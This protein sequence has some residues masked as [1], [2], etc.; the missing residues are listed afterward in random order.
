MSQ[1]QS[2]DNNSETL[3]SDLTVSDLIAELE[4]PL[5]YVDRLLQDQ[6]ANPSADDV[7]LAMLDSLTD[8]I[9]EMVSMED[10][11]ERVQVPEQDAEI[12]ANNNEDHNQGPNNRAFGLFD[13]MPGPR[14]RG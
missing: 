3:N 13:Q 6:H 14:T 5:T 2:H 1:E 8:Y 11:N 12:A 7:I 9:V 10:N 4:C